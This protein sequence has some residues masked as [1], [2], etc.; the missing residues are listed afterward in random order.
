MTALED[1]RTA[2]PCNG[3]GNRKDKGRDGR[4]GYAAVVAIASQGN[5]IL[6]RCEGWKRMA[7]TGGASLCLQ[8]GDLINM[9]HED[10]DE[11]LISFSIF[12]LENISTILLSLYLIFIAF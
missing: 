1:G 4:V 6:L 5:E 9:L 8:I 10:E 7:L 2:D 12:F 11:T 3:L